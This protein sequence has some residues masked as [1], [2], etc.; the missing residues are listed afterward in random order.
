[1]IFILIE[2]QWNLKDRGKSKLAECACILIETQWNLKNEA[3]RNI[4]K[5]VPY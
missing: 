2:T 5:Q 1:M 3:I 4:M